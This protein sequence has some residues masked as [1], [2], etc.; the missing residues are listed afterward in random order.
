M[1]PKRLTISQKGADPTKL[2]A[3]RHQC[4]PLFAAEVD[5]GRGV[6]T[7]FNLKSFI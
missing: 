4:G 7:G 2:V 1:N 3:T 5:C 6:S